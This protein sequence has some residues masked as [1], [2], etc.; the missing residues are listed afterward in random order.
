MIQDIRFALRSLGKSP[1]FCGVIIAMIALS[2]GANSAIF[3]V[4]QAVVLRPLPFHEPERLVRV[5]ETLGEPEG[6]NSRSGMSAVTWARW[7]EANNVFTDIARSTFGSRTLTRDGA[8]ARRLVSTQVSAN[9]FGV[10]GIAPVL[11]RDFR[12]EDDAAGAEPVV[13]VGDGFWRD[14]L[15]G[16]SDAIG[17]TITLDGQPHTVIGVMAPGFRHP[18]R[19]DIWVPFA[20]AIDFTQ[21][22]VRGYY[23]PARLRP[24]VTPA[25]AEASLR[26]LSTRINLESPLPNAATGGAVLPL[27][28]VFVADLRPKLIAITVAA[29]FVLLIAG[30]NISS[31]LLARHI[32]REGEASIRVA[33]GASRRV[34][35]RQSLAQSLVLAAIGTALGIV[36]AM[37]MIDPLVALS[38]IGSDASGGV[39]R[40]FDVPISVNPTVLAFS[41]GGALLLAFG[42][43]LLPAFRNARAGVGTALRG[44]GRSGMLDAGSRR[45]LRLIVVGEVA[46]AV[47]LLVSTALMIRSFQNLIDERWGYAIENRLVM[48]VTFTDR[49]RPE[50]GDR[51]HY[52]EQGLERLRMLPGVRS[53]YATSPHQMFPAYNLAAITPEG[54]TPP[55][56]PGYFL[57][58]HRMIFPG[59]FRDSGVPIVRGRPIDETDRADGQR[60]AVVS[61]G[62]AKRVWPGQDPIGKT[63]KRGRATDPRPPYVVVGVAAD[64]KAIIDR[65]DGDVIGQWYLPYAQNPNYLGDTVTFVVESA[66][67]PES[68][69]SPSRAALAAVDPSIAASN[70]NT[71]ERLV[72]ASYANDRFAVVLIG[73]FG[74]LGLM[75]AAIGLYGL[76]SFQVA[77]R[78][79]EI[80]VRSALGAEARD[81][82]VMVMREG[83]GL[84]LV[85]LVVGLGASLA[86]TRILQAQLHDI[87]ASDPI[88]YFTAASVLTLTAGLASW[89]PALRAAKVDPMV[90]LRAE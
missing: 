9:F 77:R 86:L 80:G 88:A 12:A 8:E 72:D 68:L 29:L 3:S 82:I 38:P 70:F 24:G 21:I 65:D 4:L 74:L 6:E 57:T 31:L 76:L 10:L 66:V 18:Y 83:A 55:E 69:E 89:L 22:G 46:V 42:F 53:A 63:I 75:M 67:A 73:L 33:L 17:G 85:G 7:R 71:L 60:V 45:W 5:Y 78:T 30:A 87:S 13:I 19:T 54:S 15:G 50:H 47:M 35:V 34:L 1:V 2:I 48:D 37:W 59:Y 28:S 62:F 32:E 52:V 44:V 51:T 61:E 26:E 43:G 84:M 27:H 90:A 39:L 16:R 41:I 81:I 20:E 58:Y 36:F 40:D 56:G 25:M 64:R 79:R 11:G 14:T 49:L 23:A